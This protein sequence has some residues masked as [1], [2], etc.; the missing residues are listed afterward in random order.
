MMDIV[1]EMIVAAAHELDHENYWVCMN[2][3]CVW[4]PVV[5]LQQLSAHPQTC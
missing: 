5:D 4:P 3:V 2:I 1:S